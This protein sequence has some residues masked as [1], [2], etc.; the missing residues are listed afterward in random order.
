MKARMIFAAAVVVALVVGAA[1]GGWYVLRGQPPAFCEISG[2][3]I[4]ANMLTRVRVNGEILYTCC[5]RCPLTLAA[6]DGQKV[7]ILEV[8]DFAT[9]KRLEADDA[10]FVEGSRV[11][12]CSGP[13]VKRDEARTPMIELFDRCEPSLL[14]FAQEQEARDFIAQNGGTLRRLSDLMQEVASRKPSAGER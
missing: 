1:I 7:Q 3:P 8:T 6:Q 11:H 10:F 4:H 9:G 12:M 5:A 14:A 13:R 2:R